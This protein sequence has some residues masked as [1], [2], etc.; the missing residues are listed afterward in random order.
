MDLIFKNL[1]ILDN[2]FIV[3]WLLWMLSC[4][5]SGFLFLIFQWVLFILFQQAINFV[6]LKLQISFLDHKYHLSTDLLS[7]ADVVSD[8]SAYTRFKIQPQMLTSRIWASSL[9]LPWFSHLSLAAILDSVLWF[10]TSQLQLHFFPVN[11]LPAPYNNNCIIL[12]AKCD[13]NGGNSSIEGVFLWVWTPLHDLPVSVYSLVP[14]DNYFKNY[15]Y[16]VYI[17]PTLVNLTQSL[18]EI[19]LVHLYLM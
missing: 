8:W 3:S 9:S 19:D 10:P 1:H 6:I 7:L 12:Q 2:F 16:R 13:K 5:D 4:E 11:A 18:P 14:L 15:V 17:G